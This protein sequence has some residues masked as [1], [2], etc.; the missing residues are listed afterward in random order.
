MNIKS[1][2][3]ALLQTLIEERALLQMINDVTY[4]ETSDTHYHSS[5]GKHIRHNLDH[6]SAF[7]SGFNE[8]RIDYEDRQ[9]SID[10]EQSRTFALE[11]IE[12][13]ILCLQQLPADDDKLILIREETYQNTESRQW[14][15]SSYGRELQFLLSHSIHHHAI[16]AMLPSIICLDLPSGFGI[17]PSTQ[18]YQESIDPQASCAL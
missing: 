16:I 10:I 4:S 8:G 2:I 6:L 3:H 12:E 14:L 7:I 17:A 5:V 13:L 15:S 18:R 11:K 1:A 9:R